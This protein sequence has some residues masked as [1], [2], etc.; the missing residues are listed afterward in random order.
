MNLNCF[1]FYLHYFLIKLQKKKTFQ[2]IRD[3]HSVVRNITENIRSLLPSGPHGN[4]LKTKLK[5]EITTNVDTDVVEIQND[6][7]TI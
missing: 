1:L 7:I 5:C 3:S 6:S 2:I 4:I